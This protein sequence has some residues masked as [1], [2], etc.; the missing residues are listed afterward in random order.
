MSTFRTVFLGT[1]DI[2]AHCLQ[3]LIDDSHFE[4]V[5]V[6]TQPDRP[7]GRK[8]Q[9][10]PSPVKQL[11]EKHNLE[12][13]SPES[14]NTE[15][16]LQ[17]IK[18][19]NAECAVVV[20]F[21]QLMKQ[22]FLD[23]FPDR[24]VNVHASLL[25]RW[26][27]AA[28]IQRAITEGDK[29]AGCSLQVMKL[30]LDAGDVI[31]SRK[32]KIEQTTTALELLETMKGLAADL[33]TQDF[34]DYLRGMLSPVPQDESQVTYASK[35]LKSESGIDWSQ[36]AK[37]I[38]QFVRGFTMGPGAHTLWKG[39]KVKI[40]LAIAVDQTTS[41]PPGTVVRAD[42]EGLFLACGQETVLQILKIQPENKGKMD[43][44][45]FIRGYG[46]IPG[47]IFGET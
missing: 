12:V 16:I 20:A 5:G 23:L 28:P 30:K 13:I 37:Q 31:G 34:L 44:L 17:Q 43:A 46:P 36:S 3:S 47:D 27:G 21:G 40:H 35:L 41:K 10:K 42:K 8:L 4:L 29:E 11:A 26:R 1:P 15:E 38:S 9:L 33:L 6:I 14:V 24:V 32:T 25:P 39:K 2:A 7:S 45:D 22:P 19:W 18:A